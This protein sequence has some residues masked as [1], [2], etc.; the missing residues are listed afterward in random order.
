MTSSSV[1][2][3]IHKASRL[4]DTS[5][6]SIF[7]PSLQSSFGPRSAPAEDAVALLLKRQMQSAAESVAQNRLKPSAP[8][9]IVCMALLYDK[10]RCR[11][12]G[13]FPDDGDLWFCC[14]H[15]DRQ[16]YGIADQS[17]ILLHP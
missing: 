17:E 11:M 9:R 6:Q 4:Q 7:P 10:T 15:K 5:H 3:L 14:L 16:K 1:L 13:V 12:P 2:K 8:I